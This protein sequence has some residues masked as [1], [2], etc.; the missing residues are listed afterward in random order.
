MPFNKPLWRAVVR[1]APWRAPGDRGWPS[2]AP[3]PSAPRWGWMGLGERIRESPGCLPTGR[4]DWP[5]PAGAPPGGFV[6]GGP[7]DRLGPG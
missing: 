1:P 4:G 2:R 7:G 6:G 5:A 3:P